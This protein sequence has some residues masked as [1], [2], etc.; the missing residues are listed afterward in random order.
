MGAVDWLIIAISTA[1]AAVSVLLTASWDT[2]NS[3]ARLRRLLESRARTSSGQSACGIV[4][5]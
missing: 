1:R 3:L 4:W 5:L 2:P